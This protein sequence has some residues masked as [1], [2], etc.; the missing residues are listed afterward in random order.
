MTVTRQG[1]TTFTADSDTVLKA[2]EQ[3]LAEN[4]LYKGAIVNRPAAQVQTTITPGFLLLSTRLS[5][6]VR[7]GAVPEHTWIEVKTTS[8]WYILGDIFGMYDGYIAGFFSALNA[9]LGAMF[10]AH[11]R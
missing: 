2:V 9:T 8:Q 1:F 4:A 7:T 11:L 10:A 6:I 5:I 3:T